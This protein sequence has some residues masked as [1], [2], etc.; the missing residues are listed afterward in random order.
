M[1]KCKSCGWK[2][3]RLDY[4]CFD[5]EALC[6]VCLKMLQRAYYEGVFW[7]PEQV[8]QIVSGRSPK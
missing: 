2:P 6:P 3:G 4:M 7:H 5:R 1:V 8:K